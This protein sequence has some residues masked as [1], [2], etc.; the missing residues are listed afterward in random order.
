MYSVSN[1]HLQN[2][3]KSSSL[4]LLI[5]YVHLVGL[6]ITFYLLR[7]TCVPS[8]AKI[9]E[10]RISK[11]SLHPKKKEKKKKEPSSALQ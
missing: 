1:P 5:C 7:A 8:T 2:L 4:V 3:D 9:Q 10:K 11:L 6:K